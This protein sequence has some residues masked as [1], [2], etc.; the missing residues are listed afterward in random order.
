MMK[1]YELTDESI[2]HNGHILYR[3]KSLRSFYDVKEGDIG[4]YIE[5][6]ENLSHDGNCWVCDN[7]WVY[8]D[9]W[10]CGNSRVLD[11]AQI[12]GNAYVF[13]GASVYDNA[14]V[15]GNAWV[16]DFAHV[17]GNALIYDN[18]RIYDKLWVCGNARIGGS[19]HAYNNAWVYGN[20]ELSEY[21]KV[22]GNTVLYEKSTI[23]GNCILKIIDRTPLKD[24]TLD[25]G[26]WID[27][28]TIDNKNYIISNTLEKLYIG[29][30]RRSHLI[31][32]LC[33]ERL[34]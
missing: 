32:D 10:V 17:L 19:A 8:G 14:H 30:D 28:I 27:N 15:C 21:A 11:T 25:R 13:G 3:I 22:C 34:L 2:E 12:S 20:T 31:Q 16:Y 26:I 29:D 4:G 9:A 24:I 7:A 6:E 18:A 23:S 33:P 5:K 1:K